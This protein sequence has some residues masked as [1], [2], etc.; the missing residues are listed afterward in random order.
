MAVDAERSERRCRAGLSCPDRAGRTVEM[1]SGVRQR[2]LQWRLTGRYGA[3]LV[4]TKVSAGAIEIEGVVGV[5]RG[6]A[7]TANDAWRATM[8]PC[9]SAPRYR[10]GWAKSK[11]W[12]ALN[13]V[14]RR[15]RRKTGDRRSSSPEAEVRCASSARRD[16]CFRIAFDRLSKTAGLIGNSLRETLVDLLQ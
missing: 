8:A 2:C 6:T 5:V 7:A 13:T 10:P 15:P 16:L 14:T 3:V 9:W 1:V 12:P 4:D 11:A